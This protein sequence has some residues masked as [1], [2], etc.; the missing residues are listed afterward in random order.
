MGQ[1]VVYFEINSPK[2]AEL[3]K[4]YSEAF[5]WSLDASDPS[6]YVDIRTEG[7]CPGSGHPGIDGGIGPDDDDFVTFYVQV[8]D[9]DEALERVESLGGGTILR[10]TVAG[11]VMLAMCRDPRGNRIGLVRAAP[12]G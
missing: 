8:P 4:F 2:A 11:D 12:L 1:P 5:G 7:M 3:G 10:P 9:L 6:G